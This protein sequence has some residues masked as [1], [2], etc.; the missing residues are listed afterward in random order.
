MTLADNRLNIEQLTSQT[1]QLVTLLEDFFKTLQTETL[2]LQANDADQINSILP[3]KEQQS[4]EISQLTAEIDKTL[5]PIELNLTQ[6]FSSEHDLPLTKNAQ[7]QIQNI[8]KLISDCHNL[9]QANGMSIQILNNINKQTIN[10]ISGKGQPDVSLYGSKG[11]TTPTST[12][13]QTLGKA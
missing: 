10:L 12:D 5:L 13:K 4:N 3:I 9:N 2:A 6:L 7:Q 11:K 1:A 8:I